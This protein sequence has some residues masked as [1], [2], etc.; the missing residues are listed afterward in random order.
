M[1]IQ[2][3]YVDVIFLYTVFLWIVILQKN[4]NADFLSARVYTSYMFDMAK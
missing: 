1:E 3:I 4:C 2:H